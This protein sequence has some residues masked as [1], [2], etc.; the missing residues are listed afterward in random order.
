MM[1]ECPFYTARTSWER[2]TSSAISNTPAEPS[3]A[4]KAFNDLFK[5]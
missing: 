1:N 2:E 4:R 3:G 5:F